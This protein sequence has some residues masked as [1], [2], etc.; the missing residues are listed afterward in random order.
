[1][2]IA[3]SESADLAAC[4]TRRVCEKLDLTDKI[5]PVP[6]VFS[7]RTIFLG[8]RSRARLVSLR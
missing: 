3:L 8:E 2:A 7:G 6:L 5:A 4:E 1:V